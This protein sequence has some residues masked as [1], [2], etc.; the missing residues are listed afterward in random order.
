MTRNSVLVLESKLHGDKEKKSCVTV[1]SIRCWF[2]MEVEGW[3]IDVVFE[4]EVEG[5]I[6]DVI[7][8]MEVEGWIIDEVFEMEVEGWIIDAVLRHW[9]QFVSEHS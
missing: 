4:M 9:Q 5:W 8:E 2:E 1:I 7:F 6:I 3:I